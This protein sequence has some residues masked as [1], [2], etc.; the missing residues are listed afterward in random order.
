MRKARFAKHQIIAV[1]KV[2]A[3]WDAA[4]SSDKASIIYCASFPVSSG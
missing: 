2:V 4:C 3:T 1:L